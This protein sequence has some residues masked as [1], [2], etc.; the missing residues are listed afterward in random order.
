MSA[1]S[2]WVVDASMC[3]DGLLCFCPYKSH[4]DGGFSVVFGMSY[5]SDKAPG[6]VVAVVHPDGDD[7]AQAWLDERS[8]RLALE[9]ACGV[10]P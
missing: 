7:A 3:H 4:G 5:L 1:W 2:E 10:R 9:V 8:N 6:R